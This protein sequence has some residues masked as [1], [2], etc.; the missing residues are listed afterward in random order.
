MY[1]YLRDNEN[2]TWKTIA[3]EVPKKD[4][5]ALIDLKKKNCSKLVIIEAKILQAQLLMFTFNV[6]VNTIACEVPENDV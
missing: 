6:N 5:N 1:Y 3:C 4:Y 2:D